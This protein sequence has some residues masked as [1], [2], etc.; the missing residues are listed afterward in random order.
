MELTENQIITLTYT[1]SDESGKVLDSNASYQPMV[2]YSDPELCKKGLFSKIRGMKINEHRTVTLTPEEG[3]GMSRPENIIWVE[4]NELEGQDLE[5]GSGI[6]KPSFAASTLIPGGKVY[7]PLEG[8]LDPNAERLRL[9]KELEKAKSFVVTQ[10]NKLR[11][12]KFV[13]GAPADVVEGE[14]EKL[15]SQINKVAKLEEAL[16]DLG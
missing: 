10:E 12:E 1:T 14:R 6:V 8:L 2:I 13:Q 16:R 15:R 5:I 7:V 11:N 3:F 9:G 4:K